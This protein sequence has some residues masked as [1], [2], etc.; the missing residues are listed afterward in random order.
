[1]NVPSLQASII[2]RLGV[3]GAVAALL[4]GCAVSKPDV[5]IKNRPNVSPSLRTPSPVDEAPPRPPTV[6]IAPILR[7][8]LAIDLP[9]VVRTALAADVDILQARLE[10]EA[11]QGR[12]E[13]A[14]AEWV[15]VISFVPALFEVVNGGVRATPGNLVDVSF[16]TL[17]TFVGAELVINPGRVYYENIA[18]RKRLLQAAHQEQAVV[19][20]T[21]HDGAVQY[22][23]LVL[24]QSRVVVARQN[25]L[26]ANELVRITRA[27]FDQQM[28]VAADRLRAEARLAERMQDLTSALNAYYRASVQLT[29]TLRLDPTLTL[30]PTAHEPSLVTLVRE[31][32]EIPEL[33]E[34]AATYRPDLAGFRDRVEV[35]EAERS[36]LA[37]GGFGP[38]FEASY[39]VG[40][41]SGHTDDPDEDFGMR[42]QQRF[43]AAAGWRLRLSTFGDL[44]AAKAVQEQVRLEADRV[45]DRVRGQVVLAAVAAKT[46]KELVALSSQQIDA[47]AAA[48]RLVQLGLQNGTATTLDVLQAQSSLAQGRLRRSRAVVG[49]N[50]SQVD[51]LAAVGLLDEQSLASAEDS[52]SQILSGQVKG[53][54]P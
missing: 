26:E 47:A 35:V 27:R 12:A 49:Y 6:E 33:L 40:G 32:I 34:M 22:Y 46:N 52:R 36:A 29:T 42:L 39:Q 38:T 43:Q 51:L 54:A 1:M 24:A 30:V 9:T 3:A 5:S 2:C 15:P 13:S 14:Q 25:L 18:A 50:Q 7:E 53:K 28:G 48:L 41:I 45:L 10:V 19:I 11:A 20:S 23:S 4:V 21:L 31:D 16:N 8:T 17:R 44:K 37:W